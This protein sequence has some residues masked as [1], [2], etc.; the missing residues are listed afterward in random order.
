MAEAAADLSP[1]KVPSEVDDCAA[2]LRWCYRNAL[3]AHDEAWL[4]AAPVSLD[5]AQ[6]SVRQYV[7]PLTPL[8]SALFRV[9]EG[10]FTAADEHNGAFAQFAD[11]RALW[12]LN[13]FL[14]GRDVRRARP[15]DLL[16]FRQLEQN[17]PYHS[18]IV[19]GDAQQ[20]AVYHTGPIGRGPGEM[21][22]VL[23]SDL[24]A[25][26]DPRWRP[27]AANSNFLGVYRWN[28]LQEDPR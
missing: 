15:G 12:R 27:L 2:L 16:F 6:P 14:L 3:H 13:T 1:D 9:R 25:H 8:G 10:A 5:L 20:W 26:P 4:R 7:Y 23:L 17:S 21:R 11:A 19:T 24:L 22:R 28:I 18:M